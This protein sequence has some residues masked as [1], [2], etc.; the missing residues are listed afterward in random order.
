MKDYRLSELF[1]HCK[2]L[3]YDCDKCADVFLEKLKGGNN[4]D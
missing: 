4:G 1:A 2:K 3:C